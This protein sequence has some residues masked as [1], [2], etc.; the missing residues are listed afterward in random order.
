MIATLSVRILPALA[1]EAAGAQ[2]SVNPLA[3]ALFLLF[4]GVT[5]LIT[6]R[7]FIINRT[8]Y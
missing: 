5:L 6:W 2:S 3:I 1:I 4:V 7:V 8:S